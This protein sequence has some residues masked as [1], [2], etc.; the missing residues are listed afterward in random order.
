MACSTTLLAEEAVKL[1]F[2]EA[3]IRPVLVKHC[4]E[5]HAVG[6]KE[7]GGELLV[8]SAAGLLKGG[9]SG[10]ALVPETPE[11]SM[12]IEALRYEGVEMPPDG[13][14]PEH[15]IQDFEKWIKMGAPDP[16]EGKVP[17]AHKPKIDIEKGRQFWAFQPVH[18][19]P[20][21]KVVDTSWPRGSIDEFILSR[22][23]AD[24]LKPA[25]DADRTT[26]IRRLYFDLIGLPPTPEQLDAV[27]N[28]K[29]PD[30]IEKL[31]D[32]LLES[33]Q[34]GVK[35]GRHWL[36]VAR[37]ADSNGGDFNA[38]FHNAWRYRDYVVSAMNND[39]PFDQFVREQIAGDLLPYDSDEQRAEQLIGSGFLMLGTKMLSERD[40]EKLMM[41]TVDEQI[42]TV[43]S[44]FMGM[45]LGCARCHDHKFDPIPTEDYYA[46]AGIFRSTR[47]LEGES[48]QYVSTWKRSPLPADPEHAASVK[49]YKAKMK[50]LSGQLASSK[51]QLDAAQKLVA[52]ET[53][54]TNTLTV[55][56]TEAEIAGAWKHS[57]Y[58]PNYV[59]KGYIHDNKTDKGEKSVEFRVKPRTTGNYE[60][61][62]SY[63]VSSGRANNVP[64][65]I[66][67]ADGVSEVKLDQTRKPPIDNLFAAVGK[68][69]FEGGKVSSVV[70]STGGTVGYV[71]VDAVQLIEVDEQGKPVILSKP[72]GKRGTGCGEEE[73]GRV[74]TE[75]HVASTKQSRTWRRTSPLRCRKRSLRRTE[76]KSTIAKSVFAV[77]TRIAATRS[78]V[79]LSRWHRPTT[80]LSWRRKKA[81]GGNW[82]SG[83][84]VP[85]I[86]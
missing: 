47:T 17:V 72:A 70:V 50:E 68:F 65:T 13:R 41:D 22:L 66:R 57:T 67:H 82:R 15:V 4:Y 16:R 35:W 62:L 56:D 61:R 28:D 45:T 26:L 20:I 37:Y 38:T 51:K 43:G 59:G 9:E 23:E 8:D 12:L 64:I 10:P 33:P 48:Q 52:K 85:S 60:V 32:Q 63:T 44:V 1:E 46:L 71:I 29:S 6:S 84:R 49:D 18:N 78:R 21:P 58:T 3:K 2:F 34:F 76:R 74:E 11:R 19:A 40:K 14:L 75:S 25:S 81:V 69:R 7:I 53:A 31:V 55:D 42:N 73:S 24:G 5:C 30:A 80:H 36:D 79:V 77:N 54:N 39:K 27:L 83:C 86:R